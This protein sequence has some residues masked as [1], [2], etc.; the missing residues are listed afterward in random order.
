MQATKTAA[1]ADKKHKEAI[2]FFNGAQ[3]EGLCRLSSFFLV[4]VVFEAKRR[5][6]ASTTGSSR[7]GGKKNWNLLIVR[8]GY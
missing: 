5:L 6:Q 3:R 4:V 1:A 8:M 7:L 2:A